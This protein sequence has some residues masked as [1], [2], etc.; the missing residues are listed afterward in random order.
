MA[1]LGS[2]AAPFWVAAIV[3]VLA[4]LF[5]GLGDRRRKRRADLDRVGLL[6]WPTLQMLALIA[7]AIFVILALHA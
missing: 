2:P 1:W 3:A 5:F 4:A 7:A 6:D